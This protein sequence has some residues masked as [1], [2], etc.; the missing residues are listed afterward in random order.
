MNRFL[1]FLCVIFSLALGPL[2][3]A[4]ENGSSGAGHNFTDHSSSKKQD[5]GGL[6]SAEH[7]CISDRTQIETAEDARQETSS[8]F[9]IIG[10]TDPASITVGPLLEPP[11]RA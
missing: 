8:A 4:M 10:Q 7:H 9:V 6:A 5:N 2:A 1:V 3:H 11:S